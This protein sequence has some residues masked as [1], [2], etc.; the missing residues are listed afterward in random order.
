VRQKSAMLGMAAAA[1]VSGASFSAHAGPCPTSA[2]LSTYLSG[3][4]N[5]T[6]TVL[7]K[8]ISSVS[9]PLPAPPILS[10]RRL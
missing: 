5:V 8:S 7:D 2:K 4:A 10:L 1:A 9:S 6:C 3:G